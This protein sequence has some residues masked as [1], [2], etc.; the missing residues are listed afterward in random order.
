MKLSEANTADKQRWEE[1]GFQKLSEGRVA[2]LVLAG[3]QG[4]RLGCPEPKG[5]VD[6]GLQS[7][8]SLFQIQA[9]RII[10]LRQLVTERLGSCALRLLPSIVQWILS[11]RPSV[12]LMLV[13][14]Y[15]ADDTQASRYAGM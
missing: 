5:T 2:A 1:L 14:A 15:D 8:R 3:G 13:S 4:T 11:D 7:H 9:E 12:N 10:K 6:I